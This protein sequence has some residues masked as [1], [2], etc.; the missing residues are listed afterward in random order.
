MERVRKAHGA[1]KVESIKICEKCTFK[2][3]YSWIDE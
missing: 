2:D 3:T 1:G